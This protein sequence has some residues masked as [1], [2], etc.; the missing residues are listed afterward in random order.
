[1]PVSFFNV[2]VKFVLKRKELLK[3]FILKEFTDVTGK[4]LSLHYIFC[5]DA[6]LLKINNDFLGHDYYTDIITFPLEETPKRTMAEVYISVDRVKDN[7]SKHRVLMEDEMLRVM[8]HGVLH[9]MGM[10]DK[11][12]EE[13]A[14]MRRAEDAWIEKYKAVIAR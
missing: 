6:Y 14:A 9:L 8:F 7:A 4:D 13:Q 3:A 2:R 12:E 10:H 1:M 5:S 11:T